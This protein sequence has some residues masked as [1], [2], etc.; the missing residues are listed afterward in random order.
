MSSNRT[1]L[2][3]GSGTGPNDVADP[4]P[5]NEE[6]YDREKRPGGAHPPAKD[7]GT[8]D[9]IHDGKAKRRPPPRPGAPA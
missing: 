4:H 5:S 7:L 6:H 8:N 2:P 3:T 9:A 1:G